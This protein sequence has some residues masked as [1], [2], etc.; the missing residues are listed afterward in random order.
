LRKILT[1]WIEQYL[2]N[3]NI[4]QR[5]I[6]ILFFP[7]TITYCVITTYQRVTKKPIDYQIPIISVGNLVVGGTGKTPVIIS[8]IKEN[9]KKT[10]VILRGYNRNSKGTFVV[11]DG[12]TVFGDVDNS[13]D[14]AILLANSLPN[15]IIIVSENR[16]DGIIKAKEF[17]IEVIYL[18][19]GYRH[20]NI[21][22]LDILIRPEIEPTNIFC[23]PSGGYRDT[24]M[25]YAFADIVLKEN[26]NF[27][28]IVTFKKDN[29]IIETL[30]DNI[31]FLTAISK[32]KR[33]LKFLPKDIKM[34][35]YPDHYNY[36]QIDIDKIKKEYPNSAILT[37]EKD[38]VKLKRFNLK[39]L[40]LI[41]LDII[42]NKT[43]RNK[44]NYY[45][46]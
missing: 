30:P 2:F 25:M 24:P 34:V 18:D 33:V 22:K 5:L 11:S 31:I 19:D 15:S 29:I 36:Q 3:P 17:D 13:G 39:N 8:L 38:I 43:I 10:A 9:N 26:E 4:L 44:I 37:T 42:L 12:K 14:E 35:I 21:K 7:F 23:L 41:E 27:E 20:H 45:I 32:P 28:R 6:G 16:V 1:P 46:S 40:Y